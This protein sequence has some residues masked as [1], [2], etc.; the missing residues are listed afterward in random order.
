MSSLAP[1]PA[2]DRVPAAASAT[3]TPA[4]DR[5]GRGGGVVL[6]LR[7]G[8][9]ALSTATAILLAGWMGVAGFGQ[10]EAALGWAALLSVFAGAGLDRFAVREVAI[11]RARGEGDSVRGL[12]R[13]TLIAA[14]IAGLAT[15][16][17]VC[18]LAWSV[19]PEAPSGL[20][21]V[22]L[23]WVP[24][25]A[26]LRNRQAGL[27][28]LSRVVAGHVPEL[29]V[30]P[31]AL[32]VLVPLVGWSSGAGWGALALD[33]VLCCQL[34][35]FALA[36]V[37]AWF[38]LRRVVGGGPWPAGPAPAGWLRAASPLLVVAALQFLNARI[39]VVMLDAL[40]PADEVGR[41]ACAH[42]LAALVAFAPAGD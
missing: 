29:A 8:S 10:F 7:V 41:Y 11:A 33:S 23:G 38:N 32:L 18:G 30:V 34:G 28:G 36:A 22:A 9:I 17:V 39:D 2:R 5:V 37:V 24:C 1:P 26:L 6:A 25:M 31:V 15:G 14:W 13:A 16:L 4:P 19:W 35:A 21:I 3:E 12:L 20:A 42:R 27:L 40:A